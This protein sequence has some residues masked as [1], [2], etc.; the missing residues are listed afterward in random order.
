VDSAAPSAAAK[1]TAAKPEKP[2]KAAAAA[3]AA[4]PVEQED[5]L[6]LPNAVEGQV[7]T[8]FPP[9]ASGFLHIGHAKALLVNG[10]L[11]DKYKGKMVFRFDD[12]NPSKEKHEFEEAIVADMKSLEVSYDVGPTFSSMYFDEMRVHAEDLLERGLAYAD[13]TNVEDMRKA[14][15]DGVATPCRSHTIEENKRLW[16]EMLNGTEEGQKCCLRAKISLDAPNKA[17]RDPT[18]YRVNLNPH[19]RTGL[20]YKA[21]PTYDFCCPIVDSIEGVTHA[22]RTTEYHDRNDQ[23]Y[24]F[25]DAL[26]LRKPVL[27]DFSRLNMEYALMSKRKLTQLVADKVVDGWDDP[28]FPTV[29]GLLRRGLTVSALREFVKIQ[30]M[31]KVVNMMEWA[32]LWNLNQQVIDPIAPRYA[33]VNADAKVKATVT[34]YA[35]GA[36]LTRLTRLRHKKNPDLGEREYVQGPVVFLDAEDVALLKE[37]EEV[38][39]MDWG[40]AFVRNIVTAPAAAASADAAAGAVTPAPLAVSCDLELNPTGDVKKTKYKLS[41]VA[42]NPAAVKAVV[43]E[44]DHLL[45]KKKPDADDDLDKILAKVTHYEMNIIGEASMAELKKGDFLQIERRGFYIV[46]AVQPTLSLIFV[47]AASEKV[48]HLSAKAQWLKTQPPA[49]AAAPAAKAAKPAKADDGLT[50]EEKRA[51]KAAKKAAPKAPA[52][53]A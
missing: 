4:E 32:K 48:N 19:A 38:T 50:L 44:Y 34:N 13:F 33:A 22:L 46:D 25:I 23:Y 18:I 24:W 3:A 16:Q 40:N 41:W 27:E 17:L 1:A 45:T 15:F 20:K 49:P 9:E 37:G 6:F 11:R 47:P 7:V 10:M 8:R 35:N 51:A 5:K 14:R 28:R 29:R 39:L 52:P 12:T 36:A 2:A 31:S 21:Y 30:G 42:E 43:H 53:T 26:K